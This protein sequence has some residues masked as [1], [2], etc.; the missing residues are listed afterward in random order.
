MKPTKTKMSFWMIPMT[1]IIVGVITSIISGCLWIGCY[2]TIGAY[3]LT[4]A[5]YGLNL[6][7]IIVPTLIF[8]IFVGLIWIWDELKN[9]ADTI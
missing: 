9:W 8:T 1:F 7:M 6:V 5:G 4:R 2:L 3:C